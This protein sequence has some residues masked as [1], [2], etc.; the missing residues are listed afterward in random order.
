MPARSSFRLRLPADAPRSCSCTGTLLD[1]AVSSRCRMSRLLR[2]ESSHFQDA[3]VNSSHNCLERCRPPCLSPSNARSGSASTA[4][5][6][7]LSVA[8]LSQGRRLL[9]GRPRSGPS[10]LKQLPAA[11]HHVSRE[12]YGQSQGSA[13]SCTDQDS[14]S[15]W[16]AGDQSSGSSPASRLLDACAPEVPTV[17]AVGHPNIAGHVPGV[18]ALDGDVR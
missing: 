12:K 1:K 6:T 4:W 10:G 13:T 7:S 2:A 9:K 14:K 15:D 3:A 18:V 16:R 5:K 8:H 17:V 11:P